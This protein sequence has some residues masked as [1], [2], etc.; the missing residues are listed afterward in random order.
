MPQAL[1]PEEWLRNI[2]DDIRE[3]RLW[4][5]GGTTRKDL[6]SLAGVSVSALANLE[7]GDGASLVTFVRVLRALE[8]T[9]WLET[10]R[11]SPVINPMHLLDT[12]KSRRRASKKKH[13]KDA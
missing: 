12:G 13:V 6:A 4:F 3:H 7:R 1:T 8:C 2:G 5:E 11:P 9:P 10:L